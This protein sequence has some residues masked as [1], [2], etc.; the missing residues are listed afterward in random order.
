MTPLLPQLQDSDNRTLLDRVEDAMLPLINLVF[1]LLL[2]FI[3]AGHLTDDPL[4]ALPGTAQ[5]GESSA[6]AADLIV[7][8]DGKLLV[9]QSPVSRDEL[10]AKLPKPDAD[11]P[12]RIAAD[13]GVTMDDLDSVLRLLEKAGYRKVD[14]LTEPNL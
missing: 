1:L 12:L 5:E 13:K 11:K 4:P 7:N 14:L 6:P 9:H 10:A 3:V 2:F 8:S